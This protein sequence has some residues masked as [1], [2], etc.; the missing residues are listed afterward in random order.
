MKFS[1]LVIRNFRSIDE[2]G[3]ELRFA[4][5]NNLVVLVGANGAGK[6]NVLDAVSIVLGVYPFSRFEVDEFD[7]HNKNTE[8]EL[9]IDLHLKQ[10]L[11]ERDVYQKKYEI[12]GFRFRAWRKVRGDGKGVLSKEHY[13]FGDDGKTIVK[14]SRIY[15]KASEKDP[16]PENAMRPV[17]AQDHTWKLGRTFYLDAPS[18]EGFFDKTTGFSPLGRLF[19]LYRE[20][21]PADHNQYPPEGDNKEPARLAFEKR[22]REL[23]SV[24]RT[25][26]LK[27]I[28][29]GLST[30]V[31]SYLGLQASDPLTVALALPTHQ[32]L[33][34]KVVGLHVTEN[35]NA[36][37]LPA[38]RLGSG[39]RALLRLA[40][41]E[42]LLSLQDSKD[43]LL[44]LIEE[45]EIYLHVHLQ[46]YF[47]D[48]LQKVS[49]QGH[50]IVFTT[51]STEFVNLTRPQEIVRIGK[52]PAG[53]TVANQVPEKTAF[54][55]AG[56]GRKV[57][58]LGNEEIFFA[59]HGFLTEG[60]DDQGVFETLFHK[61]G[62]DI[63]AHSISVVNCDSAG[64]LPDY[65]GL[66][67]HLGIDFYV[68]HDEDDPKKEEKR[69]QSI[70]TAVKNAAPKRQSLFKFTPCLESAMGEKKHC[71]LAK[72]LS[73]LDG[74][75]YAE[76]T[77]QFPDLIKPVEEFLATRGLLPKLAAATKKDGQQPK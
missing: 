5:D 9:I 44:L 41:I 36:P 20:D 3:V 60:Q 19:E 25:A 35:K 33:F 38:E 73:V 56:V 63:S 51:H 22:S 24:L 67:A 30:H 69:N 64:N 55:F 13:C 68:V 58:R 52:L 18:L 57:R 42:T 15:K 23:A 71:G 6:S 49:H 26:K 72:L 7:F 28:E 27:E 59:A 50:Q 29:E 14:A 46:R 31:A 11:L 39:H 76:I 34:E 74:K 45:P 16:N 12:H 43:P 47:S 77:Q 48:V 4:E 66:S 37:T 54:G 17:L 32:E 40:T 65:V 70:A 61:K 8:H 2:S 1:R 10:P 75:T 62:I 21:F 53:P